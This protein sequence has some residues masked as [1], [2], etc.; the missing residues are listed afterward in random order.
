MISLPSLI[1]TFTLR[2]IANPTR[3]SQRPRM[4][5]YGTSALGQPSPVRLIVNRRDS[6]HALRTGDSSCVFM[7]A[8]PAADI[9]RRAMRGWTPS[10]RSHCP[11]A[12]TR[13]GSALRRYPRNFILIGVLRTGLDPEELAKQG[14]LF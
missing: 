4:R 8:P 9:A 14:S 3:S 10:V 11:A 12:R 2:P 7:C 5:K 13:A 1:S 6:L